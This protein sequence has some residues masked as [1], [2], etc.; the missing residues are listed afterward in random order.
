MGKTKFVVNG[1]EVVL[2]GGSGVDS[3]NGRTG[4]VAPQD[5]DYTADMVGA[6]P[7]GEIKALKV[8]ASEDDYTST[9]DQLSG[10]LCFVLE[11]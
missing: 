9:G 4:D 1:K 11:E 7:T 5:G 2:G 6:I 8:F 10:I 3:F